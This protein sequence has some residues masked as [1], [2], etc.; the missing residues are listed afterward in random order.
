MLLLDNMGRVVLGA[1]LMLQL[2]LHTEMALHTDGVLVKQLGHTRVISATWT[3]AIIVDRPTSPDLHE[4]THLFLQF[5]ARVHTQVDSRDVVLWRTRLEAISNSR[6]LGLDQLTST[7]GPTKPTRVRRGLIDAVGRISRSLFGTA[8]VDDLRRI[9]GVVD[10]LKH[11]QGAS[12]V[13]TEQMLTVINATRGIVRENRQDIKQLQNYTSELFKLANLND[14]KLNT[15]D[16][17]IRRLQI[18]RIV[19]QTLDTL[20]VQVDHFLAASYR[21][22]KQKMQLERGYLTRDILPANKLFEITQ[23]LVKKGHYIL[24]EQWYFQNLLVHSLIEKEH[25]QL[26][27]KVVIPA[28]TAEQFLDY[29]LQYLAMPYGHNM[30]RTIVGAE[31]VSVSTSSGVSLYPKANDCIGYG[32]RICYPT[33]Q[34][35]TKA[36]EMAIILGESPGQ[37][38]VVLQNRGSMA[39]KAFHSPDNRS[40]ITVVA[41]EATPVT[42]R[43]QGQTPRVHT[44]KGVRQFTLNSACSLETTEWKVQGVELGFSHILISTATPVILPPMNFTWPATLVPMV[45]MTL[46]FQERVTVAMVDMKALAAVPQEPIP[47]RTVAVIRDNAPH[48]VAMVALLCSLLTVLYV[49]CWVVKKGLYG[50]KQRQSEPEQLKFETTPLFMQ[51]QHNTTLNGASFMQANPPIATETKMQSIGMASAPVVL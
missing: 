13:H 39:S 31:H 44:T 40:E 1:L 49:R 41:Y 25:G 30:T 48:I 19:D 34:T 43:C 45:H 17:A 50:V 32:P 27:Y 28:V 35:L 4:W 26:L 22:H 9:M 47:S 36:C 16:Q 29:V 8:T 6:R 23:K 5:M 51:T 12:L 15:L 10:S 2:L 46:R 24:P 20:Q 38:R 3:V 33:V 21:Y 42:V 7:E 37:C 11:Q 18:Q 14:D